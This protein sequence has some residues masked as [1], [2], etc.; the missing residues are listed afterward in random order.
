MGRSF[1]GIPR[2]ASGVEYAARRRIPCERSTGEDVDHDHGDGHL[3]CHSWVG[4]SFACSLLRPV[5]AETPWSP[6]V[7]IL[8]GRF[9]P[10]VGGN[11]II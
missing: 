3:E 6:A 4:L 5:S 7:P 8:L 11:L 2:I 9:R 10:R 1:R